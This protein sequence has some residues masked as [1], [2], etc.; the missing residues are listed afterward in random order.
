MNQ[1]L[2]LFERVHGYYKALQERK[3]RKNTQEIPPVKKEVKLLDKPSYQFGQFMQ[4]SYRNSTRIKPGKEYDVDIG[5]Y[6]PNG[7]AFKKNLSIA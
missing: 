1:F 3:N 6:P 2:A 5:V 7:K 4:G